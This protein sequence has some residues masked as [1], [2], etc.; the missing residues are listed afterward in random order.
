LQDESLYSLH[1]EVVVDVAKLFYWNAIKTYVLK[2]AVV[3]ECYPKPNHRL[4]ADIDCYLLP[5]RGDFDAWSL[6][7]DLIRSK[8]FLCKYRFL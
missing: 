5:E 3:S 2:G 1:K 6:G 7:N 4:S 8:G